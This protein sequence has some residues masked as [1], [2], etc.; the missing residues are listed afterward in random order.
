[1]T[2]AEST[3]AR[4]LQEVVDWRDYVDALEQ[5]DRWWERRFG[6]SVVGELNS[7]SETIQVL[8][9]VVLRRDWRSLDDHDRSRLLGLTPGE[10]RWALLGRMRAPARLTVFGDHLTTI[11]QIVQGVVAEPESA[12]PD[13][14]VRAFG[15]LTTLEGVGPGIAT[16]L[17][18]LARPDRFVSLNGASK[19]GLAASFDVAPSTLGQPQSYGRLLRQVYD[20]A[21]YSDPRP[22]DAREETI[23]WMRAALL[24]CFVYEP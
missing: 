18:T 22:I 9:D 17:L 8:H 15:L 23:R 24:D 5:C 19:A 7:W 3:P 13:A 11:Q 21:W 12:F 16:R 4:L 20:E 6:W 2:V 10:E 1:M 14:A